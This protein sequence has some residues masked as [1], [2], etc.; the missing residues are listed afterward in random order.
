LRHHVCHIARFSGRD[1]VAPAFTPVRFMP[2]RF[3][4]VRFM[5]VCDLTPVQSILKKVQCTGGLL[6]LAVQ[7]ERW[8]YTNR[9]DG[10][11]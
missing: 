4:P 9:P 5:P 6:D 11:S 8:G 7:K 10:F 1:Y 3:M 2:V